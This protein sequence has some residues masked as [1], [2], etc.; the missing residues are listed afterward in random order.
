MANDKTYDRH[1]NIWING[2]EVSNNISSIKKEML[3]LANELARTTRG[4]EEY[5]QKAAELKRVKGIIEEH[6]ASLRKTPGLWEK[7]KGSMGLV[8]GAIGAAYGVLQSFKGIIES[9]DESS[10]RLA[11]T[12]G[13]VKEAVNAVSQ[14]MASG[15][16]KNFF[17]NVR[18]AVEE[19]K[20]YADAQDAAGDSARALALAEEEAADKIVKLK[21]IQ[22][23]ATKS[24]EEQI[25]AGEEIE[26]I[27]QELAD[28]RAVQAKK[29]LDNELENARF[30]SK[31]NDETILAYLRQ[32]ESMMENMEIGKQYYDKVQEFN[33]LST[34]DAILRRKAFEDE[35][36]ALGSDAP[37]YAAIYAG[38]SNITEEQRDRIVQYEN[39]VS[40]AK[41]SATEDILRQ[42]NKTNSA[43]AAEA[44]EAQK[45]A[46]KIIDLEKEVKEFYDKYDLW[47]V[48]AKAPGI[49]QYNPKEFSGVDKQIDADTEAQKKANEERLKNERETEEKISTEYKKA[50]DDGA[51]IWKDRND[52]ELKDLEDK[53]RAYQEF[54]MQIG[55]TLAQAMDDGVLT[56]KEAAKALISVALDELGQ[57]AIVMIG[58]VGVENIGEYGAVA[59][60]ARTVVLTA[61]IEAAVESAKSA[62]NNMWTGGYTGPGGK[63]EPRGI[64]HA[65]EWVANAD[66][67]AS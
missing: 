44:D 3:Q 58:K 46:K 48:E 41:R 55:Q 7:I 32:D 31:L 36:A 11:R 13:G 8:M 52:S 5:N 65:G 40:T 18:D 29:N 4:T 12:M 60:A 23:D 43:R 33:K 53:V 28:K 34:A 51:K 54:G 50:A 17:K 35:L 10:D 19:G 64:V 27:Q 2:K 66:M 22:A 42:I 9:T 39:D 49:P 57:L 30:R 45:N 6:N 62:L 59:G 15:N 47:N 38:L 16:F 63:Y 14:A 25:K 61:L 1:V 37:K 56:A 21:I 24:R 26:R 20:R 67:V